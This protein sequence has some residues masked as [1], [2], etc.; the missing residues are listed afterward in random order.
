MRI[1][2]ADRVYNTLPL[3]H[4]TGGGLGLVW[5]LSV[6]ATIILR[7]KFS[8]SEFWDDVADNDATLFVYIGEL[9]RY[10]QSAQDHP[11]QT[12]HRLRAGYGNGLRGEVWRPFVERFQIS[13]MRELY[14]STEGNVTFLNLDGTIGAIG[15]MSP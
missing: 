3:Y 12:R 13:T 5:P 9:C 1:N 2:S 4:I 6:G 10:L 8:A 11:R 15:Q 7:R 14:G